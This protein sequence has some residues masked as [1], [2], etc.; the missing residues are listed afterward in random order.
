MINT[1]AAVGGMTISAALLVTVLQL[2]GYRD[3]AYIPVPGD[4]PTIGPGRTGPDVRL[5]DTT[6]VL[7]EM[8][9][10]LN[11]LE[12]HYGAGIRK[13]ITV[14]LHQYE[15]DALVD[16]AYNAG[17]SAVCREMA[18]KFNVART[19]EDYASACASI[20]N[21]RTTVGGR[22]CKNKKNNCRGLIT[23]RKA[24]RAQCE[25]KA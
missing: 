14:P 13:C 3:E 22:D 5:G 7:R 18:T 6:T 25:G 11:N 16:L 19:D 24:Q 10:L 20:E 4:V 23:R 12:N 1:R 8:P 17:V 9:I 21:W 2:E 15:F